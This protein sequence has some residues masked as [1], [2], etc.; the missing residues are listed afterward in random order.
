MIF[1]NRFMKMNLRIIIQV[2]KM[3]VFIKK[4]KVKR[5]KKRKKEKEKEKEKEKAQG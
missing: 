4:I 3:V 2:L 1:L 5:V